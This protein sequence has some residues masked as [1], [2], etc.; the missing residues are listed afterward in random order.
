MCGEQRLRALVCAFVKSLATEMRARGLTTKDLPLVVTLVGSARSVDVILAFT[1]GRGD[2]MVAMGLILYVAWWAPQARE[3]AFGDVIHCMS[4]HIVIRR[5]LVGDDECSE[6]SVGVS[7]MVDGNAEDQFLFAS[8]EL[9]AFKVSAAKHPRA[10]RVKRDMD[11]PFG[12]AF[13]VTNKPLVGLVPN[14]VVGDFS[15]PDML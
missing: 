4:V 9:H 13:D 15:G 7:K 14:I 2:F 1:F 6:L 12:L 11:L 10:K 3:S 8:E 5:L